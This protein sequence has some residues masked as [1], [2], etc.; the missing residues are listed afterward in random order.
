[1]LHE[2][3]GYP[4]RRHFGHKGGGFAHGGKNKKRKRSTSTLER[5]SSMYK[6]WLRFKAPRT[7][8]KGRT[9]LDLCVSSLRRG[10][11][12][13][14]CE[15]MD[16]WSVAG[17]FECE[18]LGHLQSRSRE[19]P[20][21]EDLKTHL[22]RSNFSVIR[23]PVNSWI[24]YPSLY[25]RMGECWPTLDFGSVNV[26]RGISTPSNS[27]IFRSAVLF[28]SECVKCMVRCDT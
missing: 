2:S 18:F 9:L 1:M 11:A 21:G 26:S 7:K 14:L 22:Y 25:Q 8:K 10:H 12:N 19:S 20:S 3:M 5:Y 16:V 15:L 24:V 4:R 13:L 23:F 27:F 6:Q 17:G 28:V